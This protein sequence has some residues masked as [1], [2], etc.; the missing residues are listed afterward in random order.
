SLRGNTNTPNP[1]TRMY[2]VVMRE[3]KTNSCTFLI[4]GHIEK[5]RSFFQYAVTEAIS[6]VAR[7]TLDCFAYGSQ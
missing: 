1:R 4:L 2:E 7:I 5:T 3:L 6:R